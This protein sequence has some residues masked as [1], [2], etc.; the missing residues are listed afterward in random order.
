MPLRLYM[1]KKCQVFT[2]KNYV[3]K[4]LDSIGYT[5]DLYGK[6]IL[7]NSCGD[8]NILSVIV[9]RYIDDCKK[10]GVSRT[11][12][13]NGLSKDVYGVEIDPEQ[14]EKCINK[15]NEIVKNNNVF[16]V[17]WNIQNGDYLKINEDV[18]FDF[19]VGNPP[20][21]TYSELSKDDQVYLKDN[22]KSCKKG[23]F[24]Y[25]YAFLEKSINSLSTE[26][27]M[28]YLIPSSV[29]KTV[30]GQTIRDM[31]LPFVEEVI[32]HTQ[33]KLFKD[34]LVK[35]SILVIN[36]AKPKPNIIY[37]DESVGTVVS[38]D[39]DLLEDKWTFVGRNTGTR[40]FGDYFK[41][42]HAVATLCNEAFVLKEWH[43]DDNNNYV[44]GGYVLE[45]TLVHDAISPKN[46]RNGR[47]EKII[48]PYKYDKKHNLVRYDE[49]EFK[50]TFSGI[51][52]YL[53]QFREKLD[54]RDSDLSAKWFEY[55]RS[56]AV[57]HLDCEKALISTIISNEVVVYRLSQSAIPYS[58][59]YIRAITNQ[60]TID[61]AIDV[62]HSGAFLEYARTVGIP[63]NGD[64]VRVTSKDIENYLF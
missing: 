41:V 9:Q 6:T 37:R 10:K 13:R 24:D 30:F 48:F 50:S 23:R 57:N 45:K 58:G 46:M 16:P 20:Y 54:E 5:R 64:S 36:K 21:I 18:K 17:K 7:E 19:I 25:C 14:Y 49:S 35:S 12:I 29:Y 15:L 44:C 11:K 60:L 59:M 55:G 1:N 39:P 56:Q 32:E 22:F 26:G 3:E 40:R 4:L 53:N 61:D 62:L 33:E 2:P 34:A 63:I 51:V 38:L 8:G 31:M 43:L 42:S 27:R 28:A 52:E 47:K